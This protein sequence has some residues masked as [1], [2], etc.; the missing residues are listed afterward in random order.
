MTSFL[1]LAGVMIALA[2]A[3]VLPACGGRTEEGARRASGGTRSPVGVPPRL[4][5]RRTN[6]TAQLQLRAS[7]DAARDGRY[8]P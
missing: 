5:L 2:L 6:A 4:L 8:P 1:I 3:F 7:W